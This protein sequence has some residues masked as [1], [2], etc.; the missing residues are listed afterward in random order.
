MKRQTV[1]VTTSLVLFVL[2]MMCVSSGAH[3]QKCPAG[4]ISTLQS[5][6]SSGFAYGDRRALHVSSHTI[7]GILV[8]ASRSYGIASLAPRKNISRPVGT[9]SNKTRGPKVVIGSRGPAG[10]VGA[11][12]PVG[13]RGPVGAVGP[14]GPAGA[15]GAVGPAGTAGPDGAVGPAGPDGAVGPVGPAGAD[16]AAGPAGPDG[17]DAPT[18]AFNLALNKT[19][20]SSSAGSTPS[21][22][23]DG[24][25]TSAWTSPGLTAPAILGVDLG[26]KV[27]LNQVR[28]YWTD[29]GAKDFTIEV[30]NNNST[31]TTVSTAAADTN[32]LDII[33]FPT[34]SDRYIR[35]NGTLNADNIY[36]LAEFEVY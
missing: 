22:A 29:T 12:G 28:L 32:T 16:G 30:S 20:L 26:A 3:A 10:P 19:A 34:V 23:M 31:W 27:L 6:Q 4:A 21:N 18:S 13:P 14:A 9:N 7:E 15:D 36:S 25:L 33:T 11:Q 5:S 2:L 8:P 17:A 35:V 1:V 24:D